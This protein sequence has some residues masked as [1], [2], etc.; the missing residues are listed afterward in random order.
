MMP[1]IQAAARYVVPAVASRAP[2]PAPA[3]VAADALRCT[4]R[5]VKLGQLSR[6][7]I[8]C[9]GTGRHAAIA[10][11]AALAMQYLQHVSAA[12][13]AS[14]APASNVA[15]TA[16]CPW[17]VAPHASFAS[18]SIE[19]PLEPT[20]DTGSK[21]PAASTAR[22]CVSGLS[23]AVTCIRDGKVVLHCWAAAAGAPQQHALDVILGDLLV[24]SSP[25]GLAATEAASADYVHALLSAVASRSCP[26]L[27]GGAAASA[28][29]SHRRQRQHHRP[30]LVDVECVAED[31]LSFL[32][33]C[34]PASMLVAQ[35]GRGSGD[36]DLPQPPATIFQ[37]D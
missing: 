4:R 6:S 19:E 1:Q 30:R 27:R 37:Q 15:A 22:I 33:E 26:V 32:G 34:G 10:S 25:G 29:P 36:D 12:A 24:V 9:L 20:A 7:S 3:L 35:L 16:H 11:S 31:A 17:G 18:V 2:L 8:V 28:L 21:P 13:A 14:I 5:A 23:A